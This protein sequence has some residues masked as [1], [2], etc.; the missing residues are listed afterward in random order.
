MTRANAKP[1]LQSRVGQECGGMMNGLMYGVILTAGRVVKSAVDAVSERRGRVETS[2]H[3][4]YTIEALRERFKW[5]L[6][7]RS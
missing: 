2:Q 6:S 7:S 1:L 5:L 3:H 4:E